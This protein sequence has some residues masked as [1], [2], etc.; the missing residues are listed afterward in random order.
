MLCNIIDVNDLIGINSCT[1]PIFRLLLLPNNNVNECHVYVI[2]QN[3]LMFD[4][5]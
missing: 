4:F 5:I 2:L 3:L 1:V